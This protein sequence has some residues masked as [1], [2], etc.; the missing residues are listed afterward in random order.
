MKFFTRHFYQFTSLL[1]LLVFS[2]TFNSNTLAQRQTHAIQADQSLPDNFP[3]ISVKSMTDPSPGFLFIAPFGSWGMF[4]DIDSYIIIIDNYGHPV[5]YKKI[6][7][8]NINDFK[9]QPDGQLTYAE[10]TGPQHY[11]MNERMEVV[12]SLGPVGFWPDLHEFII[13]EDGTKF[14][15]G[16]DTRV[17]DMSQYVEGGQE[18]ATVM[19]HVVQEWDANNNVIFEWD[20]WDHYDILDSEDYVDLTASLIDLAHI[21]TIEPD[22]D[23]SLL[24]LARNMN[25]ITKIDRRTG[26]IIWRMG[27]IHN[28]FTFS[29]DTLQ[30]AWPHDVRKLND[31]LLTLFDNGRF[32]TPD[33]HFSSGVIY[34]IDEA[35]KTIT[36]VKRYRNTP[37]V[38]GAIMGNFDL[39][40]NG[41]FITGWGSGSYP[42]SI[43]ISEFTPA[44]DIVHMVSLGGIN[45][46]AHKYKW[47]PQLFMPD[48]DS[49]NLG[50]LVHETSLTKTITIHNKANYEVTLTGSY[51]RYGYFTLE[52]SF[53]VVLPANG[54]A[55][56]T[57]KF[58]PD[59]AG[60]F[61]DALTLEST[62]ENNTERIGRQMYLQASAQE[63][64]G[65]GE[66][67]L[68]QL[69]LS[70]NPASDALTVDF[71]KM[72]T[73]S[74]QILSITGKLLRN[75]SISDQESAT[76][77]IK[78]LPAGFYFLTLI[79]KEQNH[80][81][82][83]FIKH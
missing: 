1:I 9:L 58:Q 29:N 5:Y 28:E 77:D 30:W 43:A 31:T 19:G 83:K 38:Y 66:I 73:G 6:S 61:E 21:N 8:N 79:S 34:D 78:D 42:D 4:Q 59:E 64:F 72:Q 23:T 46:R 32:N 80:I 75:Y 70:P 13:E 26:E 39:L 49:I 14:L 62:N 16:I 24:V 37:D 22:S 71:G 27:G 56:I 50:E 25:E 36:L 54:S 52:T 11:L 47:Q 74:I 53:P 45:Y 12:D 51:F 48:H 63:G 76:L 2:C 18:N 55:D 40:D 20:T 7:H 10:G 81:T 3:D 44:G 17:I 69:H 65:I 82:Q 57:V 67:P 41:N 15:L 33:P 35:N 60:M 68:Q